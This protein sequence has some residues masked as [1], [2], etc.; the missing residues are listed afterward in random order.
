MWRGGGP[1]S[2]LG[3]GV[4]VDEDED[5]IGEMKRGLWAGSHVMLSALNRLTPQSLSGWLAGAG[6]GGGDPI[7]TALF[8]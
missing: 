5:R 6:A 8:Q 4:G 3:E 7:A 2:D 1:E